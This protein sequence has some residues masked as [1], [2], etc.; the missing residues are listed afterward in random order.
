MGQQ[1]LEGEDLTALRGR[2]RRTVASELPQRAR[3][4]GDWPIEADHCFARVVLDTLFEDV[5]DDHVDGSPAYEQLSADELRAANE[6]AE[7][8]LDGGRSTVEAL[9]R[10]SLERRA[11]TSRSDRDS[12]P[13]ESALLPLDGGLDGV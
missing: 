10:R 6:I 2:Y 5:W 4:H 1:T 13:T 8:M 3:R 7:R 11:A 9:N 12:D